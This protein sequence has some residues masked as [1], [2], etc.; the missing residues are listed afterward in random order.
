MPMY[1]APNAVEEWKHFKV[2][3][4]RERIIRDSGTLIF[5]LICIFEYTGI[6]LY[7]FLKRLACYVA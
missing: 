5:S 6:C 1:D 4:N 3:K 2:N 7:N